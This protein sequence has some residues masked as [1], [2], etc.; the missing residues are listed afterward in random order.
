MVQV[1]GDVTPLKR[2]GRRLTKVKKHSPEEKVLEK[3]LRQHGGISV[4]T[5]EQIWY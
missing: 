3:P 1:S 2:S 5:F 4:C